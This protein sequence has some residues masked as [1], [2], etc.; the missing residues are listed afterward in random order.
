MSNTG[1][2]ASND[3]KPKA[4]F[5]PLVESN[6]TLADEVAGLRKD[7]GQTERKRRRDRLVILLL[8]LL[9]VAAA[10][11]RFDLRR[12]SRRQY[13][14][15]VG[16]GVAVCAIQNVLRIEVTNFLTRGYN[17]GALLL[18]GDTPAIAQANSRREAWLRSGTESFATVPCET[19]VQDDRME[20]R[21]EYPPT[22]S[23]VPPTSP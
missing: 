22:I 11:D 4:D 8:L 14:Q 23:P 9:S 3:P 13:E 7:L 15:A 12:V 2:T 17:D 6:M 21:L 10:V 18:P 20:I 1:G 16:T 5:G 19:L